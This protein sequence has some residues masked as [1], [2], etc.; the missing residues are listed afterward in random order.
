MGDVERA[1]EEAEIVVEGEFSTAM[2]HQG[3]IEPHVATAMWRSDGHLTIWNSHQGHFWARHDTASVLGLPVSRVTVVP[4]EIGGGFGGKTKIYLEPLA[5]L[6][7]KQSGRPVKMVMTRQEVLEAAGPTSGAHLRAKL[8]AKRDGTIIVGEGHFAF[9]AGAYP[10]SPSTYAAVRCAF[11]PY[12]IP[13]ILVE[14][15]DVVLNKPPVAPYRAPGAPASEFAIESLVDELAERLD[16]DPLELR[17]KNA[18]KEGTRSLDGVPFG[19]IGNV[20]VMDAIKNSDHYRSELQGEHRGRGIAMGFWTNHGMLSSAFASVHADGTVSLVT[21][22]VDIGG[23]RVVQAM[24]LAETLG[25]P[26]EDV[27]LLVVDTDQLGYNDVTAGSRTAFATGWASYECGMDIRRQLEERAAAIWEV[28]REA[29]HY[30]GD[31]VIRGPDG[32]ELAFKE[33]AGQLMFSGGLI[34]GGASVAPTQVGP[35]FAGHIVDVEIDPE[36]G[37]VDILRYTAVQD[38]GTAVHPSY[39]EGQL[40]GGAMQGIGMAL[41]EEYIYSDDGAMENSSLLDYRQPTTV[42]LPMIDTILV[43]VPNPGHPYGVRGVAELPIVPPLAAVA[44]A[45]HDATGV[46]VPRLPA[47]PRAMLE[48]LTPEA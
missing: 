15:W 21:G 10:G 4:L 9:E 2:A 45:I 48:L 29:V 24:Q 36:T 42:D 6:L 1:F 11:T 31:A 5:A 26:V 14:A 30:D 34:Q 17:L 16:M 47:T 27:N 18:T 7:S 13:N 3:Y 32:Q 46:R 19:V 8:G 44:N 37:K 23:V 35:A 38:V 28:D 43:E 33:L 25:I 22:S 40:Q 12:D 20:E 41:S 39:V